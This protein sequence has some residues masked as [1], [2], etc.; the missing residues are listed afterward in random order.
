[1]KNNVE[2]KWFNPAR[3]RAKGFI[4]QGVNVVAVDLV[5]IYHV[6]KGITV[7]ALRGVNIKVSP[8]ETISVMG[9]SGSG[10]TTL[11]N[12][13]GGI[14]KP[15]SGS[16]RV[17]SI[18]VHELGEKDLEKYRLGVVGYV[19]Q[20]FNLIPVLTAL[21]NV[22]L[23]MI[24]FNVPRNIRI[25]RAKW[26]L[27]IVGLGDRLYH[28]PYELSGGQQQRVA[29]ATALANDPPLILADEPTAEL[30]TENALNIINLLTKLSIEY[31]KTVIVSTHDPRMAIRTHRIL[32]LEDGRV[33]GEYK[34]S[35]LLATENVPEK[36][37]SSIVKTRLA[38][39]E[40]E[41]EEL[42]EK[43]RRNEITLD[44]FDERYIRLRN[45][46]EALRDLLRS[47]GQ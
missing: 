26:L 16:I 34:P 38:S 33:I 45:Q 22:E 15:S 18:N 3:I 8:G 20:T 36:S 35:E 19:F 27:E 14:D 47:A 11:L 5:K 24:A 2:I 6:G 46:A 30:D 25:E 1:M 23:P 32:R 39:I 10:K 43:L 9:P 42:I 41:I 4:T 7:Q 29:I 17:N 40:R 13:L 12:L 44:E 21:E 28:K 37:L 31:G